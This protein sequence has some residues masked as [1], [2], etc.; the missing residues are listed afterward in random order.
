MTSCKT[1]KN[2]SIDRIDA[3]IAGITEM[4]LGARSRERVYD[5]MKHSAGESVGLRGKS[6][7]V[8]GSRCG[9]LVY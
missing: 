3:V 9:D 2:N 4:P 7:G 1:P 5:L 6:A 8:V